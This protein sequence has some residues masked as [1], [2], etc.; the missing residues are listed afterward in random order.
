MAQTRTAHAGALTGADA[1][2]QQR[3]HAV[4]DRPRHW[5]NA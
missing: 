1:P 5:R 4:R 2:L 3:L